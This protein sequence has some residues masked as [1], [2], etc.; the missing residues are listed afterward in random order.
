MKDYYVNK[1]P[2]SNGDHEVHHEDCNYL[3]S[4][5]NRRYLGLFSNCSG[6]VQESKKTYPRSNGCYFCSRECHTG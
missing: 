2:Q 5:E 6:A 3:P 4:V 1:N